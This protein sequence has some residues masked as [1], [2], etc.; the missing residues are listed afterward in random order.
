MRISDWSSDVCSSD[1]ID[2][3]AERKPVASVDRLDNRNGRLN[4]VLVKVPNGIEDQLINRRSHVGH[5]RRVGAVARAQ[6][7]YATF[8]Q[9]EYVTVTE[10][11]DRVRGDGADVVEDLKMLIARGGDR[12]SVVWGARVLVGGDRVGRGSIKKKKKRKQ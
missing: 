2:V 8:R 3:V 1:L 9:E 6:A 7:A 5:G 12:T 11:H 4:N 10:A